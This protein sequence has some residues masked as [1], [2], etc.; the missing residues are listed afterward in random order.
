[1]LA[2]YPIS[3]AISSPL[4][5]MG[6]QVTG[7]IIMQVVNA[8]RSPDGTY[9]HGLLFAACICLPL[10]ILSTIY[11]APNKRAEFERQNKV[12]SNEV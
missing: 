6:N 7:F 11:N 2:T 10:T 9:T 1:L 12:V 4:L 8:L 3:E 5:W